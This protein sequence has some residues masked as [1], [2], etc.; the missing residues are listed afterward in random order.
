MSEYHVE[1]WRV[2]DDLAGED[3]LA[4]FAAEGITALEQRLARHAAFLDYCDTRPSGPAG[5]LDVSGVE[6]TSSSPRS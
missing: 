2:E 3:W 5:S 6:Q 1:L 4:D